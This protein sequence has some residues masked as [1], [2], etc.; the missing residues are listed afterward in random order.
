MNN[1]WL[2]LR[3]STL[4]PDVLVR[5]ARSSSRVDGLSCEICQPRQTRAGDRG[6]GIAGE[7]LVIDFGGISRAAIVG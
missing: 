4:V 6:I 1:C 7:H 3:L 2:M 5:I